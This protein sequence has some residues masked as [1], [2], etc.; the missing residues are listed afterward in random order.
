M[1]TGAVV[2]SARVVMPAMSPRCEMGAEKMSVADRIAADDLAEAEA[3][4]MFSD[5]EK[6]Q[7]GL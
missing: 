2:H 3:L 6:R 5:D 7:Y 1:V 4:A